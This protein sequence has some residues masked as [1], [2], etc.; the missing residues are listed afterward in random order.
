MVQCAH[1]RKTR[2]FTV[3]ELVVVF[4]IVGFLAIMAIV[5]FNRAS[6]RAN[7]AERVTAIRQAVVSFANAYQDGAVLCSEDGKTACGI[8]TS[9]HTCR[10]Y[11]SECSG[12]E[13]D[14]VTERYVDLKS[15]ADP[16]WIEPCQEGSRSE[17]DFAMLRFQN[18]T[19]YELG[20]STEGSTVQGL[21]FGQSHSVTQNGEW[22]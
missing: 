22:K 7:D 6:Q 18:L 3:I 21:V 15:F 20:F 4:A 16:L 9:L 10:I 17:C 14:D 13:R 11:A 2:G 12:D 5:A 19:D 1:M 8:G